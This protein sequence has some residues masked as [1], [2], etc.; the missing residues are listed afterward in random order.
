MP[1]KW[2]VL[3]LPISSCFLALLSFSPRLSPQPCIPFPYGLSAPHPG[4]SSWGVSPTVLSSPAWL[5]P[6]QHPTSVL[7]PLLQTPSLKL[8]S[9][10]FATKGWLCFLKCGFLT[11]LSYSCSQGLCWARRLS[12][13][14]QTEV[15]HKLCAIAKCFISCSQTA[16]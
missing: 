14:V 10:P 4:V 3:P 8:Q 12:L 16:C 9:I 5:L 6:W 2:Q 13:F 11:F 15:V 1:L 7:L